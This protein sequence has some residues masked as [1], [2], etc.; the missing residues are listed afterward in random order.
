MVHVIY[1]PEKPPVVE[2]PKPPAK[3]KPK[4][5]AKAKKSTGPKM[6][7]RQ[8]AVMSAILGVS[9]AGQDLL[10]RGR[11]PTFTVDRITK[12]Y[13]TGEESS[14]ESIAWHFCETFCETEDMAK[15]F[16]D[17]VKSWVK[18]LKKM[19]AEEVKKT[20]PYYA[21]YLIALEKV[22]TVGA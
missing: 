20:W 11:F 9:N 4:V 7:S 15:G 3:I 13:G 12:L 18:K 21:S 16:I 6:T 14:A 8:L 2:K 5:K 17:E 22:E 10:F 1:P 19:S